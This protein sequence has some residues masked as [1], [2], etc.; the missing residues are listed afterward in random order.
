MVQ[1]DAPTTSLSTTD[2]IHRQAER[3]GASR[4]MADGQDPAMIQKLL[5][6]VQEICTSSEEPLYMAVQ[7]RPVANFAPDAVVL[8]NRRAI[9][10]RQ[11]ILG[12]LEFVDCIW[13]QIAGIHMKENMIGATVSVQGHSGHVEVVD[14]LPKVQA[15]RVY[16]IGQEMEEEMIEMRRQRKME[17]ERNAANQVTINTAVAAPSP[18]P[19]HAGQDNLV[20]RLG[21]LKQMLDADLITEAEFHAKKTEIINS[22]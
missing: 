15:R 12:R 4:F 6:R 3:D 7:Q 8:T 17:E 20:A 19:A 11:K 1:P 10:F 13:L 22:I 5:N 18:A 14:Y 9:I 2:G 16:R 21:Q